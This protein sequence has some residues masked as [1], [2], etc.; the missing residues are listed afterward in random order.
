MA[1]AVVVDLRNIYQ[2]E[3]MKKQGFSY[4]SIGRGKRSGAV[5]A[6]ALPVKT[7]AAAG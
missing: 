4:T 7:P 3:A 2:A 5:E 1:R 6:P